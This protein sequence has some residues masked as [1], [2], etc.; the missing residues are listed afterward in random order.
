M[1]RR[2]STASTMPGAEALAM[3]G[4]SPV[5]LGPKEG[6]ALINGT[7]FSTAYALAGLFDAWRAAQAALVTSALSTDAIMGSTAPLH[8]E[9]HALRGHAGPDRGR[10]HDARPAGRLGDPRK[11]PRGRHPRAGPLLHPLP[12]A[13]HRGRDGR[14]A[15][16]RPHAGDRGERRHR[17]PAGPVRRP[18]RLRRQLPRRTRG[19]CRRHD[20]AGDLPRSAPSPSA[21]WR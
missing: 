3:A 5:T 19:F 4:L 14:A 15:H 20:R 10:G 21:A 9:I 1:A 7:Q 11:P 13:G 17:Q 18:D 12:A 8:P 16:G 6:L 2:R